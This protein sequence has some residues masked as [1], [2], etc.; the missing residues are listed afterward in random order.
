METHICD[1]E[2]QKHESRKD[3]PLEQ[4]GADED[5]STDEREIFVDTVPVRKGPG[6]NLRPQMALIWQEHGHDYWSEAENRLEQLFA[7]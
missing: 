3:S 1:H 4:V 6:L 5:V 7:A 2:E